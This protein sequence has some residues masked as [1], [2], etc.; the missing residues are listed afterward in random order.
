[1]TWEEKRTYLLECGDQEPAWVTWREFIKYEDIR[2][3][4][5]ILEEIFEERHRKS[6][7]WRSTLE[8]TKFIISGEL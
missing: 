3:A 2:K 7:S 6:K 8:L 5:R 4:I 1:M